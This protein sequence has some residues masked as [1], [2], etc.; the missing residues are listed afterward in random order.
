[1]KLKKKDK[2]KPKPKRDKYPVAH[3]VTPARRLNRAKDGEL[4]EALCGTI[5]SREADPAAGICQACVLR[6]FSADDETTEAKEV[7]AKEAAEARA[8]HHHEEGIAKGRTAA[9]T[10]AHDALRSLPGASSRC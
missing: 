2:S 10:E 4:V 7:A 9:L 5:I 8:A 6:Q 3:I 1:M